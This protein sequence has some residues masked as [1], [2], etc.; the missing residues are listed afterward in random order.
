ML[1]TCPEYGAKISVQAD[2][3]PK[4]GC[5]EAGWKSKEFKNLSSLESLDEIDEELENK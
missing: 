4:C 3:C 2:P 1:V 5:P